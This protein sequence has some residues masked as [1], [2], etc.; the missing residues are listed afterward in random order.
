M[1]TTEEKTQRAKDIADRFVELSEKAEKLAFPDNRRGFLKVKDLS[2]RNSFVKWSYNLVHPYTNAD[3][4]SWFLFTFC[5][6]LGV[7]VLNSIISLLIFKF[8]LDL[9]FLL[10]TGIVSPIIGIILLVI[11]LWIGMIAYAWWYDI[12]LSKTNPF[13]LKIG[14]A[15]I[16]FGILYAIANFMYGNDTLYLVFCCKNFAN[17]WIFILS[18][19]LIL[20]PSISFYYAV[21]LDLVAGFLLALK[22]IY[23]G[24]ISIHT[25]R[26]VEKVYM[27]ANWSIPSGNKGAPVWKLIDLPISEI[28]ILQKW[29]E[30]NREGS[31]KRT[32]PAIVITGLVGV[33]LTSDLIRQ[34]VDKVLSTIVTNI[35][36]DTGVRSLFEANLG[37]YL[38]VTFAISL[39]FV[40]SITIV[41]SLLS[42]FKNIMAQNL[43]IEACIV[44]EHAVQET[45]PPAP[46][47]E[48]Q[49]T[50]WEKLESLF[51]K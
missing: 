10:P 26:Q 31:E 40:F 49:K 41:I 30:A 3:T 51:E 23:R 11:G 16:L 13:G 45:T 44:A 48:P 47:P 12:L 4:S 34:Q 36:V 14:L 1:S 7:S 2:G 32:I 38:I 19:L 27:L 22:S 17:N 6:L 24:I 50:F 39:L 25:P 43:I 20:F 21:L 8:P 5:I 29:A 42:L 9:E 37:S 18:F 28:F 35:F 33:L 15:A 46:V